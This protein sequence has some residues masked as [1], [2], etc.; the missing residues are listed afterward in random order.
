MVLL[1][2]LFGLIGIL[3]LV[4]VFTVMIGMFAHAID[5][6]KAAN[7]LA[8]EREKHRFKDEDNF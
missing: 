2:W 6:V 1:P 3:A 7:Y 4:V 5:T 8:S